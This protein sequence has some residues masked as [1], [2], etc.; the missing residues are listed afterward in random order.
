MAGKHTK[1]NSE[2]EEDISIKIIN[3]TRNE[4]YVD[5]RFLR[6]ALWALTPKKNDSL[7]S[8]ATNGI[9]ISYNATW[10]MKVYKNNPLFV[11]SISSHDVAL[12]VLSS[13]VWRK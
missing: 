3:Q 2:W 4:L 9:N 5:L 7:S 8:F 1:T 6:N 11:N 10:L 12:P 13:V